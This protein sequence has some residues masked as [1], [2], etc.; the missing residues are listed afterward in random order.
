VLRDPVE[1]LLSLRNFPIFRNRRNS[2]LTASEPG[3]GR[4]LPP[5]HQNNSGEDLSS[6][7][8]NGMARQLAGSITAAGNG[9]YLRDEGGV[10][11]PITGTEVVRLAVANLRRLDF[12]GF[13]DTLD[14]AYA[15]V[16]HEFGLPQA[17]GALPRRGTSC[18]RHPPGNLTIADA[19]HETE[20]EINRLI[21]LDLQVFA[22]ARD[23]Q[24]FVDLSS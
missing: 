1:R 20:T 19:P 2:A 22:A 7:L 15:R 6:D 12:V 16:A 8:D 13:A 4:S 18:V 24:M 5:S 3:S 9:T 17:P 10:R 23:S 21:Q 11:V 14:L